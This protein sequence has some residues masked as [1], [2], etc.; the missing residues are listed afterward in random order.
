[1]TFVH[2]HV[3]SAYSL[4]AGT[5]TVT[6]LAERAKSEGQT[7]LALTDRNVLYGAVPFYHACKDAGIH[8]VIGMELSIRTDDRD[9]PH[10]DRDS[11]PGILVLLAKNHAGY[12]HLVKLSTLVQFNKE[13]RLDLRT[14]AKYAEGLIA[15][16]GGPDGDIDRLLAAGNVP[17]AE[18]LSREL[19]QI[20]NGRFYLECCRAYPYEGTLTDLGRSLHIPL[21]AASDIRYL[22]PK[23]ER[24][25]ACLRCI[26]K[27]TVLTEYAPESG[28]GKS[29]LSAEEMEHR[30]SDL[31]EALKNSGLIAAACQVDFSFGQVR[32]PRFPVP[33]GLSSDEY[34]R[35]LCE[36]ALN[37]YS[38][39]VTLEIR[40]RLDKELSVIVRMG[41]SDYFLIVADLVNH[42]RVSGFMPG[43]G[44][45]SAA[46]SLVAFLL[47]I[48]EVDPIKYHLLFERFLNPE[49]INMPD[50]DMDFP[51][52]DR[53][54]MIDYAYEKYGKEHVAQ[55]ITFGTLAAKA[56]IRDTGRVMGGDQWIADR[57]ARLIP[58]APKMT[59]EKA[60]NESAKLRRLLRESPQASSIFTLARQIEGLPRHSSIH[61]AGVV[62]SDRPLTE[63]VPLQRGHG[64]IPVTQYPMEVLEPLGLLKMDFLGLR[65]LTF[66][67]EVIR[68]VSKKRGTQLTPED[69]PAN[70]TETFRMLGRG[71]TTGV[72]Q[73]E[74][75]GMRQVLRKLRPTEFED[76]VAVIALYRPGPVQF[77]D[78]YVR[79]K[80]GEEEIRYPHPDLA[81][82]LRPT[83]GVLVYQEQIMQIAVQMAG[84]SLGQADILRRAV[85]KKKRDL[86]ENQKNDFIS[87]CLKKGY[88]RATA[89]QVFDLIVRFADYGFNRAHAVAYGMIS[90]RLAYLKA[91]DP[92]VF[93]A[94]HLTSVAGN[95]EKLT[96]AVNEMRKAGLPLF[97]PSVN[98]SLMSFEP[99]GQGIRFGLSSI[100]N[101]GVG[102]IREIVGEREA[103]GPYRNLFDL[104]RRISLR[105][106][107]RKS[108]EYLI[109]SGALDEFGTD[110]AVLLATLDR[111][112]QAGEDEQ[113]SA[114]GQTALEFSDS[115]GEDYTEV[116]PLTGQ[117]KLHYEKEALGFYLS[118]HPLERFRDRL[119]GLTTIG[120]A[121]DEPTGTR[122]VLAALIQDMK[123]IRTRT[124]R[125]MAFLTLSDETR[126]MDAVCFSSYYEKLRPILQSDRLVIVEA[127]CS[128]GRGGAGQLNITRAVALKDYLSR[129]QKILL[130]NIDQAHYRPDILRGLKEIIRKNRGSHRIILHYENKGKTLALAPEYAV[131]LEQAGL[132][133]IRKLIGPKNVM[134]KSSRIFS[135]AK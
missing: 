54:K 14:V 35:S 33:G 22:D 34:L 46:G 95:A 28:P 98:K 38:A 106:V 108:L 13:G 6:Q 4:L 92:E 84:Y 3:H 76:I 11:N 129:Y 16:S 51:D 86:L 19:K 75:D 135:R 118:G 111:A 85:G 78:R 107:N 44:R 69:I 65:N 9:R 132:E 5:C 59:L 12:V 32:V 119:Y 43:P 21:V 36:Q 96:T 80:H 94:A 81:P 50:I 131:S 31:P 60:F 112:I 55:I 100:K 77:I 133:T 41:F 101:L 104:C 120:Q 20:F 82:I 114:T 53:D 122:C 18:K 42:A 127:K 26:D 110:R 66:M 70:D 24:A 45:G 68:R 93:M 58:S 134:I 117:E 67:R 88:E 121:A 109:F 47:K 56:A 125:P 62:L 1:M 90:Y 83:W 15:L 30:F 105:K 49:R 102:A 63:L 7:A 10:P 74:S 64:G 71:D 23:D 87:G 52:V 29:Y 123:I 57:L 17:A 116:P 27:G 37:K 91:H 89:E 73:L 39:P 8:P 48:T 2:L 103:S 25:Y 130:L 79:R 124:G 128:E 113:K 40:K 126:R 115:S 97:P 72:F 99:S 61:A